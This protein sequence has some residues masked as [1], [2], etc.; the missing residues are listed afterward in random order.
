MRVV[1]DSDERLTDYRLIKRTCG[2]T[3]G[4]DAI[5]LDTFLNRPFGDILELDVDSF[6]EQYPV[7]EDYLQFL[8]LKHFISLHAVLR[9]YTGHQSGGVEDFCTISGIS[10]ENG[11]V[12]ID[13][14]IAVDVVTEKI[15]SCGRCEGCGTKQAARRRRKRKRI[16][17]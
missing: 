5:L 12:I 17:V 11:S 8:Y 1:L 10:S 13:A 7:A 15:K 9:V 3:V 16:R 6:C 14:E 4:G 2:A